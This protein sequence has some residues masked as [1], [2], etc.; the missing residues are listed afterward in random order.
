MTI[1]L[2]P[3][4]FKQNILLS[5]FNIGI[6]VLLDEL[7]TLIFHLRFCVFYFDGVHQPTQLP[8]T[9]LKN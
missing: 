9:P 5:R 3:Y 1:F 7:K 6:F 8:A 4:F 2:A